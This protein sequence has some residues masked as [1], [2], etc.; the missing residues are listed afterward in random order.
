MIDP[1][2]FADRE[3]LLVVALN[4]GISWMDFRLE[5]DRRGS[6]F[7]YP[8]DRG[9]VVL[10]QAGVDA[11]KQTVWY[12]NRRT[13]LTEAFK[14]FASSLLQAVDGG[15]IGRQRWSRSCLK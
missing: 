1:F 12:Q 9:K 3:E 7:Y 6:T 13:N 4:G 15:T 14:E 5:R 8:D 2:K 11:D 10:N